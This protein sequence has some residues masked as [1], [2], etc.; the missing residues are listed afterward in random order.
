MGAWA[1]AVRPSQPQD[2]PHPIAAA[3]CLDGWLLPALSTSPLVLPCPLCSTAR[4]SLAQDLFQGWQGDGHG[5][6]HGLVSP[7]RHGQGRM[8]GSH[9]PASRGLRAWGRR[10]DA[11]G[12]GEALRTPMPRRAGGHGRIL[13]PLPAPNPPRSPT[14][15]AAR[16]RIPRRCRERRGS[17]AVWRAMPRLLQSRRGWPSGHLLPAA[18]PSP[19]SCRPSPERPC[20]AWQPGPS[21]AASLQS[22]ERRGCPAEGAWVALQP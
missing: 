7:C 12:G 6:H 5:R 17:L 2:R 19:L 11:G 18:P 20:T 9:T 1:G 22:C 10:P 3:P 13:L 4:H 21:T 8:T 16:P 15:S 14:S